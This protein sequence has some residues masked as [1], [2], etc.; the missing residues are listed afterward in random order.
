MIGSESADFFMLRLGT[1]HPSWMFTDDSNMLGIGDCDG[2]MSA[3]FE[4][5]RNQV[6]RIR[7]LGRSVER[8]RCTCERAGRELHFYLHGR[9]VSQGVWIGVASADP[10]YLPT[11]EMI[12]TWEVLTPDDAFRFA[13]VSANLDA[14]V[15]LA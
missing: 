11:D 15:S 3:T 1:P 13:G 4:L 9:Q 5:D 2:V 6:A 7:K 14:S 12:A 8:I 10:D